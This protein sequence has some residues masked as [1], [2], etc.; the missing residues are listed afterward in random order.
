MQIELGSS[1]PP[2]D[3]HGVSVSLPLWQD[4]V[5]WAYRDE[6]VLE[7]LNTGYPRFFVPRIVRVL[8]QQVVR[9]ISKSEF[10]NVLANVENIDDLD[11]LLVPGKAMAMVCLEHLQKTTKDD[12]LGAFVIN[13]SGD[14]NP[15]ESYAGGG[16]DGTS[17]IFAIIFR[18]SSSQGEPKALWQHTGYGISSRCA[19]H[20]FSTAI[21]T[22]ASHKP[23]VDM[24]ITMA[25]VKAKTKLRTRIADL[26]CS[27]KQTVYSNDVWLFHTGM[28]AIAYSANL[29]SGNREQRPG[30][31]VFGFLYVDT[32]K[33]LSKVH[34]FQCTLYNASDA[35]L[36]Q[37]EADL[38]ADPMRYEA[39]YLEF[40]GNPLLA[41]PDLIR[42]WKL[43][44]EYGF[45]VVLDDTV[46]TAVNLD[47]IA[48]TDIV[49][50]SLT[51]M[52]SG[53]CNAMG[54]SLALNPKSKYYSQFKTTLDAVYLDTYFPPD[55][56]IMERNSVDFAER[57]EKANANSELV[58]ELLEKHPK[59]EQV[60]YPKGS[61]SQPYYDRHRR[62]GGGYGFLLSIV[63]DKPAS[64]MAFY[65]ALEV[66]KGPSLGTNFT[67]SCAYTLLAHARELEWAAKYGVIEY[68]V[69]I[70]V[71]IEDSEDLLARVRK[72]LAATEEAS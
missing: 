63:F 53:A 72:A 46:G 3:P 42:I 33:V 56:V 36:D 21:W 29:V 16:G 32:F 54:G 49:C 24:P 37:L 26:V 2:G 35:D 48:H 4:T 1:L 28:S 22:K 34:G 61:P 50:T 71:G 70:S 12:T 5:G 8:A 31:A 64:A 41:S 19:S 27:E 15:L 38:E 40:P 62:E 30:V 14:I 6:K 20:W 60:Y 57:V 7:K 68:L 59:V 66:A 39:L 47:L 23:D 45:A 25:T 43:S 51:K 18:G 44:R 67:L 17:E 10:A 65:D 11:A 58:V 55:A 13:F 52:F 9:H 69:R